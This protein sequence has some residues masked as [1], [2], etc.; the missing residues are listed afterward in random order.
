[1][2]DINHFKT[3]L[4][5][6]LG[7]TYTGV[8]LINHAANSYP[9]QK[10]I[11]AA[12]IV[13]PEEDEGLKYSMQART[14]VR[15]RIRGKK[16]FN[17]ARR[18]LLLIIG[19][20]IK[21]SATP[22]NEVSRKRMTQSLCGL[23]KRR[24]YS[25]LESETDLTIL[26]NIDPTVF[27][28]HEILG[29]FF[30]AL[31][32]I[33]Q[34]W[35]E[36]ANCLKEIIAF[37]NAELPSDKEFKA[38]VKSRYPEYSDKTYSLA[39]K[40]LKADANDIV[41]QEAMGHKHRLKYLENIRQEI[42]RDSRLKPAIDAIG[43]Q[44]R[45]WRL[46]GNISNLQLRAQRWYFNAPNMIWG[47]RLELERLQKTLVRAFKYFHPTKDLGEHFKNLISRLQDAPDI[48]EELC[49]INPEMTIPPYEDQ[50]NRRPPK[51]HT[52]WLNPHS[53][54]DRYGEVWKVWADRL[55]AND[56]RLGDNLDE[57]ISLTD[58]KS[59]IPINNTPVLDALSYRRSYILQRALDRNKTRDVFCLRLLAL[60]EVTPLFNSCR[61]KLGT[62]IGTQHLTSFLKF[63]QDYYEELEQAKRGIWLN[64]QSLL[65][66]ADIHPPMK[67]KVLD[68][69][70]GNLFC[71][72]A[73]VGKL[74]QKHWRSR[75]V[76]N[77]SLA[78]ICRSIETVRKDFGNEFNGLYRQ[79]L[80]N[81][82][83]KN[84]PTAEN[85]IF[86]S[87]ADKIQIVGDFLHNELH[88][89][90]EQ[91]SRVSNPY[92]LA[93]LFTLIETE[94]HGF[95]NTSLAAHLENAWRMSNAGEVEL[96]AQAS[97]LPADTVRPF[98][99]SLRRLIDRQSWEVAKL[100][101]QS[102]KNEVA[103]QNTKIDL[104]ILIEEN[105]FEF[106]ASLATIKKNQAA[107][108]KSQKAID[109]QNTR[110]QNKEE[111]I[112]AASRNVCAYTGVTLDKHGEIDHII[113]R[114]YTTKRF[115][116]AFN[117]EANL[118]Y[119]SQKG[120]Q[121]K[122]ETPYYLSDLHPN[123]LRSQFGE[124]NTQKIEELISKEVLTLKNEG[125]LN[126]FDLL[127]ANEQKW[128]RHALFLPDGLAAKNEVI[129][130]LGT[131]HKT[132]VNGTQAWFVRETI[133]KIEE[134]MQDWC[135][136]TGN[137]LQFNAWKADVDQVHDLRLSLGKKFPE[138]EKK[139]I[140]PVASHAMDAL[141]VYAWSCGDDRMT[142]ATGGKATW[143]DHRNIDEVR[144]LFPKT[145]QVIN[146]QSLS[147]SD[148]TEKQSRAIFKEGILG[149]EFLPIIHYKD[150]LFIGYSL[151]NQTNQ[152]GN[153]IMVGGKDPSLLLEKL[154]GLIET[155]QLKSPDLPVVY[156]VK[157][158]AAFALLHK[159][160]VRPAKS[161]ELEAAA[162][163]EA[164]YF[165]TTRTDVV[166]HMKSANGKALKAKD[167]IV[168]LEKF[169][170][171]VKVS[172]K[173][174]KIH[175]AVILPAYHEWIKLCKNPT[176]ETHL[177]K[178]LEKFN[179]Q[180]AI[181]ML[182]N[183]GSKRAHAK[184]RRVYSL[185]ILGKPS[186]L[187]RI[188]RKNFEGKPITQAYN[189]DGVIFAG[190]A[191]DAHQ[192][193]WKLPIIAKNFKTNK[194]NADKDRFNENNSVV[195]MNAYRIVYNK[196]FKIEMAPGTKD[197]RYIRLSLSFE[198]FKRWTG[199]DV[200]SYFEL[201][202]KVKIKK[203][204]LSEITDTTV[205]Q[206]LGQ[207]RTDLSLELVGEM[208]RARYTVES[209]NK[210]MNEAYNASTL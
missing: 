14:A 165:T 156:R 32:P 88:L 182:R 21:K 178:N 69:L 172:L 173:N 12:T 111:R 152:G 206:L 68:I 153:C 56:K 40:T 202:A 55:L 101:T 144:A 148:K 79:A 167:E 150:E 42:A 47:D 49:E 4:A 100:A 10:N 128:V 109:R 131:L 143:A 196:N 82:N 112:K 78:S 169:K 134:Q 191:H 87:I 121:I 126:H 155:K 102:I 129:S 164:L 189:V 90:K 103:T 59:R 145:C 61:E 96:G 209:S 139:D 85:K 53:L 162:I 5:I 136:Q 30:N 89:S 107:L 210:A 120:N 194:M 179:L 80:K 36:K 203:F 48:I 177:G 97:R 207:P 115:G 114:S 117:S 54:T 6:D 50:N 67:N 45:L 188:F 163:L 63:A 38:Y 44:D 28:E 24:G 17:L 98:D 46:V 9:T 33:I 193:N 39:L 175:G 60:G 197:R 29:N 208:I 122:K 201:P 15:H 200:D 34:Q 41:N 141:C 25:R 159:V 154:E 64:H 125:R 186:G 190:F 74:I 160:A 106:S 58:R 31:C 140:Q 170:I 105:R 174:L 181:E 73:E 95:T 19:E 116:T 138:F 43:S 146:V 72:D 70:I 93:Q 127:S 158:D 151:P 133:R 81:Q 2:S 3:T 52:L 147:T 65:E 57:I 110:W 118:I 130:M 84:K 76:N 16:R 13:M 104:S 149:Q 185:P 187:V 62:C 124:T 99:G 108:K 204:N 113:S 23:L 22:I 37:N 1:M 123:Y 184:T 195:D 168:S 75:I 8:L 27:A 7:A 205:C 11:T 132:R 142:S 135:T 51:D 83:I 180:E 199:I 20:A 192:V 198:D 176:I 71:A 119:V 166:S 35:E 171:N 86:L 77:S 183:P 92:S 66:R 161:E 157:K 26:E 137:T 18:L 91:V 94:R